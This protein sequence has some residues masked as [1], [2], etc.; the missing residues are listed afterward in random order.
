MYVQSDQYPSCYPFDWQGTV[1]WKNVTKNEAYP[2][3]LRTLQSLY[4]SD[5]VQC[6]RQQYFNQ[7]R[8]LPKIYG[9]STQPKTNDSSLAIVYWQVCCR[10]LSCW[11]GQKRPCWEMGKLIWFCWSVIKV[12]LSVTWPIH[13]S[14]QNILPGGR[15]SSDSLMI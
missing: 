15:S 12:N 9:T 2:D 11:Y 3:T 7:V 14:M 5:K 10:D 8:T 13:L 6:L 4:G 1:P